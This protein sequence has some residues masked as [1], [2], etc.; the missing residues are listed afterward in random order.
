MSAGARPSLSRISGGLPGR[1]HV[2]DLAPRLERLIEGYALADGTTFELPPRVTGRALLGLVDEVL[3][4][5]FAFFPAGEMLIWEIARHEGYTIPAY[6]TAGC[7]DAK[8]FLRDYGATDV[9][10]WYETRGVPREVVAD[11]YAWACIMARNTLF[12]RKVMLVPAVDLASADALAPH[13]IAALRFCRGTQTDA[14]D[15]TLFRC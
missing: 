13:L 11:F 15:A 8:E 10:S 2:R 4:D 7:G 14:E 5:D 6:P 1:A 3:G 12:W 9:P